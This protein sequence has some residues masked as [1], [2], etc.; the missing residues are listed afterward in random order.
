MLVLNGVCEPD[1]AAFTKRWNAITRP[2]PNEH[3]L[4]ALNTYRNA[5]TQLVASCAEKGINKGDLFQFYFFEV[6]WS[7]LS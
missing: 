6:F 5:D 4:R 3:Q 7:C 2:A 1:T